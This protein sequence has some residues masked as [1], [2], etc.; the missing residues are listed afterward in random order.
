[1]NKGH[2]QNSVS[3]RSDIAIIGMSCRLPG[4]NTIEE[5]WD[6]I[7]TGGSMVKRYDEAELLAAG[8]PDRLI[9]NPGFVGVTGL[10]QDA[11]AFDPEFFRITPS[12]AQLMDP[13]HRLLLELSWHALEDAG[14]NPYQ[15]NNSVG[16]FA[17]GGRH[18]YLRYLER[19]FEDIDY[20][21]GSIVGLQADIGNYGDF[22]ATRISYK[23]GLN[24]PSLNL[25]TACS[26]GL[27]VVHSA[28]QSL[29]LGECDVALAGAVNLH[30][31]QFMGYYYEEGS[32]CSPEGLLRP[33]DARA[34]GSVFGNGGGVVVLKK[35]D[36]ALRDRDRII[37]I[38][39]STAI[40][41]DG[42]DKMSF[43]APSVKGQTGAIRKAHKVANIDPADIGYVETHGTGTPLGDPIE[44]TALK[45]AFGHTDT[46]CALGAVKSQI[47]H[48]GPAAGIAGLIKAA[49]VVKHGIIP[50]CV[51]HET[52]NPKCGF[53]NSPFFVPTENSKWSGKRMAGV[54]AFGVGGTNA[55]VVLE[56]YETP[57]ILRS[58][59][60]TSLPLIISAASAKSLSR[61]ANSLAVS[62][63]KRPDLALADVAHVL[64]NGRNL[65]KHRIGFSARSVQ[66]AT[67]KLTSLS[68]AVEC[69]EGFISSESKEL[70]VV[71]CFPG[72]GVQYPGAG[73]LLFANDSVFRETVEACANYM[74]LAH[75]IDILPVI[76]P[77]DED[78]DAA[79]SL[80]NR[81]EWGQPAMF[82]IEY[83]MACA[84]SAAGVQPQ[85]LIAHSV[86]EYAAACL[87][88]VF[89]MEDALR[90]VIKRGELMSRT[91][92]GAMLAVSLPAEDLLKMLPA[93]LDIAAI[94]TP[95]QT[96]VSGPID[97][98]AQFDEALS[99]TDLLHTILGTSVAAHSSTMEPILEEFT[100]ELATVKLSPNRIPIASTLL[101]AM[102]NDEMVSQDYWVHHLRDTVRYMD[103]ARTVA[104]NGP[105]VA[106]EIGPGRS[107]TGMFRQSEGGG[108]SIAIT[109]LLKDEPQPPVVAD[110]AAEVAASGGRVAWDQLLL[111]FEPQR[112]ALPG[113]SFNRG[114]HWT[115][116]PIERPLPFFPPLDQLPITWIWEPTWC[117]QK[118]IA[119]NNDQSR[120][121]VLV[122]PAQWAQIGEF[123]KSADSDILHVLPNEITD[124]KAFLSKLKQQQNSGR[125]V[126]TVVLVSATLEDA[127]QPL[128]TKCDRVMSDGFWPALDIAKSLES[129]ETVG[130]TELFFVTFGRHILTGDVN[131]RPETGLM[132]GPARVIPQEYPSLSSR[133]IDLSYDC[134][135]HECAEILKNELADQR[136]P[137]SS[138]A[139]R[140]GIRYLLEYSPIDNAPTNPPWSRAG[141][142]L[143][144]GGLGGIGLTFAE[145]AANAGD[146]SITL[147]G[148][149]PV[150][151][152]S[153]WD[154]LLNSATLE[155][156][157]HRQLEAIKR[158]EA[159]GAQVNC[160][161]ADVTDRE[162]MAAVIQEH[163]PFT[164]VV[165]AAGVAS[166]NLIDQL[167]TK[168]ANDVIAPKVLGASVLVELLDETP[169]E[170]TVFCSSLSSAVGGVGHADY[171][172]ANA[173]LDALA[174][175]R[176]AKGKRT[177]S[178]AYDAWSDIGM[179]AR[180]ADKSRKARSMEARTPNV[181][182]TPSDHPLLTGEWKSDEAGEFQGELRAG[183]DWVVDEH[184][185]GGV[186]L[187]PGTGI[188]EYLHVAAARWF[189]TST[190]EVCEVDL[191][192]PLAIREE[193]IVTLSLVAIGNDE[194]ISLSLASRTH[195]SDIWIEHALAVA[196]PISAPLES[197]CFPDTKA[198]QV[199]LG[200]G[201]T[202]LSFGQR[203]SNVV[204]VARHSKETALIELR[205][206]DKFHSD[207]A[208]HTV[209]PALLDT[210][211]G[212]FLPLLTQEAYLPMSY[213]RILFHEPLSAELRSKVKLRS[214][215]DPATFSFDVEIFDSSDK[216]LLEIRGY[217]LRRIDPSSFSST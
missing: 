185:L 203:W 35:L 7:I 142:Y 44:I 47:G 206:L 5:Y 2:A 143:I 140:D 12:E 127:D 62:L 86:G 43:T 85:T 3:S 110:V 186:R 13:Q 57:E 156:E 153:E 83:A 91:D 144:T 40:N 162:V 217:T 178:L 179:A 66:D 84:M 33:F 81:A 24:G 210:A 52:P 34:N 129:A 75:N 63:S 209:H 23:L 31:P 71:F 176:N 201:Q 38:V 74:A 208:S 58:E 165:H 172:S 196:K 98:I 61:T 120:T 200:E 4:A 56:Q 29:L 32:L 154:T 90:L 134:D 135:L 130:S 70:P 11:G 190:V 122:A 89:S 51:N 97:A 188:V 167:D 9:A 48:L 28:C 126:D 72:M 95:E 199:P 117:P 124:A 111:D 183:S 69:G 173:F 159:M 78:K 175:Q 36:A 152:R 76:F 101:G 168:S 197:S 128:L 131:N 150:P 180:E 108:G 60:A 41:N 193:E 149:R 137:T 166:G 27:V 211:A 109:P 73:A 53:P 19:N 116:S 105:V 22:L 133:E 10:I 8:I 46:V 114:K 195:N 160:I 106:I 113:Y 191:L 77:N 181:S 88:G 18:A 146:V 169:P 148:R 68:S 119:P 79:V 94:N 39:R 65:C 26:T 212:S 215:S 82:I 164:G 147:V 171:S 107:A 177:L 64:A 161:A 198:E 87:A 92:P 157:A 100:A 42:S 202:H 55:H 20:L 96:V 151:E 132:C 204:G 184:K 102:L 1:M 50:A 17:G 163:G 155:P 45:Q 205:L 141:R 14:Y 49:L 187:L 123:L 213:E 138:V 182:L 145:E 207:F 189:N 59:P 194:R 25:Q 103:A 104:E 30:T 125:I 112:V 54:S 6:R 174:E 139:Y 21:D 15:T 118:L 216:L 99:N 16:M 121:I 158:M 67:E 170:W 80:I 214:E 136:G 192:G 93:N 37:A 115:S